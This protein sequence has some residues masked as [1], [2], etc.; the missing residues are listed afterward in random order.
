MPKELQEGPPALHDSHTHGPTAL[1]EAGQGQTQIQQPGG[2]A[3]HP[4]IQESQG[5]SEWDPDA[6]PYFVTMLCYSMQHLG[7]LLLARVCTVHSKNFSSTLRLQQLACR[8]PLQTSRAVI[9]ERSS[10]QVVLCLQTVHGL[11][12][13]LLAHQVN[14]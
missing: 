10:H 2:Q 14:R 9:S 7:C 5:V 4:E 6:D 12:S 8:T 11:P 13:M 1:H 3:R